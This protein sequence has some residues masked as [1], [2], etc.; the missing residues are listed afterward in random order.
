MLKLT[1]FPTTLTNGQPT[2]PER[3]LMDFFNDPCLKLASFWHT[4]HFVTYKGVPPGSAG[5]VFF[6][7]DTPDHALG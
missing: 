1:N 7:I 6:V 4:P 3:I 5:T 2:D